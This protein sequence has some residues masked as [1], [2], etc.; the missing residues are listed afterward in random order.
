MYSSYRTSYIASINQP[1]FST[2]TSN[3]DFVV[4]STPTRTESTASFNFHSHYPL[5]Y[6]FSWNLAASNYNNR[7]IS[8][9]LLY[10]TSGVRAIDNAWFRYAVSPFFTN[11]VGNPKVGFDSSNSQWFVNI[12]GVQDSIFS[13]TY[14]WY[15]RVR[16]YASGNNNY[17][18]YT[19]SI[20]NF[21]GNL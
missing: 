21:N 4:S 9:I 8:H 19:S 6:E 20:Y 2:Y 7:N 14:L 16:L 18:Y 12:T 11:S 10:F 13:A 15:V 3:S 17:I 5:T 1:A